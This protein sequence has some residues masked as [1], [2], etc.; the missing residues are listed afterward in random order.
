MKRT[1]RIGLGAA[2]ALAT[3][4]AVGF[5]S[6]APPGVAQAQD[7]GAYL[8]AVDE[9]SRV[10]GLA[11]QCPLAN[12]TGSPELI[13]KA[14]LDAVDQAVA[15]GMTQDRAESMMLNAYN[16]MQMNEKAKELDYQAKLIDAVRSRD[17]AAK[18]K[19]LKAWFDYV[20]SNCAAFSKL[21]RFSQ[22]IVAPQAP[23]FGT[24]SRIKMRDLNEE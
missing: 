13:E 12:Y 8:K 3:A 9:I 4:L 14:I 18:Q 2:G 11:A 16:V 5:C 15:G 10:M 6:F 24:F 23:G 20:D 1:K 22:A 17:E 7:T 19:A 21:P